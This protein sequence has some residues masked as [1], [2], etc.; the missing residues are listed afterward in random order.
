MTT[1]ADQITYDLQLDF[2]NENISSIVY[3]TVT[4]DEDLSQGS[5]QRTIALEGSV[6]RVKFVADNARNLRGS[7]KGFLDN[8]VLATKT[9]Q[10]FGTDNAPLKK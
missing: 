4:V 5:V 10:Y 1:T 2:D 6:I 8:S 9:V 3:R 7:V